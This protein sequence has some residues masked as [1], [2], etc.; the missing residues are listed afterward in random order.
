MPT[1]ASFCHRTGACRICSQ[2]LFRIS[3]NQGV[4]HTTL[5]AKSCAKGL[6]PLACQ[7]G[8]VL[9]N[10]LHFE[11]A[12]GDLH[13][14]GNP[15]P[16]DCT[17]WIPHLFVQGYRRVL[18]FIFFY[19]PWYRLLSLTGQRKSDQP[20][21]ANR[22]FFGHLFDFRGNGCPFDFVPISNRNAVVVI[23]QNKNSIVDCL[24]FFFGFGGSINIQF[25]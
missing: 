16:R 24:D 25:V 20:F 10:V 1:C 19:F 14:F 9:Q 8:Q 11:V 6:L 13:P 22:F 21:T 5:Q 12:T 4:T 18:V 2:P 17:L 3:R 23:Y 15:A 7:L